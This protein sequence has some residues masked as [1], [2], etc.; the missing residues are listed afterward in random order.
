MREHLGPYSPA[1]CAGCRIIAQCLDL[2]GEDVA[3]SVDEEFL[4]AGTA[5]TL[6]TLMLT[7]PRAAAALSEHA[8]QVDQGDA[9]LVAIV[10]SVVTAIFEQRDAMLL[11]TVRVLVD[12]PEGIDPALY[13]AS[14]MERT[15]R[16]RSGSTSSCCAP[17][18]H[19]P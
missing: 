15:V 17:A 12:V 6:K 2:V 19:P 3:T 10:T 8:E 5:V 14:E 13:V 16:R 9:P 11:D 18:R 1:T 4:I 7:D